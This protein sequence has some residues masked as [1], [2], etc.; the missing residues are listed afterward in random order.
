LTKDIKERPEMKEVL[1]SLQMLRRS[2]RCEKSQ[3]KIGQSSSSG[4]Q[5]ITQK[6][7][8]HGSSIP[9]SS[10]TS[11]VTYKFSILDIFNRKSRMFE[12]N[13]GSKLKAVAINIFTL[14]EIKRITRNYSTVISRD[15]TGFVYMGHID[16]EAVA[17]KKSVCGDRAFDIDDF[18][19]DML[20]AFKVRHMNIISLVGCCLETEFPLL[21]CEFAP[22]RSLHQ[23]LHRFNDNQSLSLDLRLGIAIGSAQALGY[24][25]SLE[26]HHG[27]VTSTCI[28]LGHDFVPKVLVF[29]SDTQTFGME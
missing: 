21:V 2:L 3:E 25:H 22:R 9:S 20:C 17:V 10:S 15:H 24:L 7:D 27:N 11:S 26:K 29:F 28:L 8:N 18:V 6:I 12:S 19:D 23:L 5:A 13:R 1:G 14:E 4:T 16:G